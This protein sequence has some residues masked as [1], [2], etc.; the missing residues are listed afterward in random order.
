ML[1]ACDNT[2]AFTVISELLETQTVSSCLHIFTYIESRAA[3]LTAGMV[4]QKGK[5]LV[6]LKSLND[7][8]KR[9]SRTGSSAVL[10]GRILAFLSSVFPLGERSGQ[11]LRGEYGPAWTPV[12]WH[13]SVGDAGY[14]DA[15]NAMEVDAPEVPVVKKQA[16]EYNQNAILIVPS[17]F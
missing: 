6:F 16:G 17:H 10:S 12:T 3:R 7:L 9:L 14:P 15:L 5:A 13:E 4:P 8:L 11:N 1:G 2:F